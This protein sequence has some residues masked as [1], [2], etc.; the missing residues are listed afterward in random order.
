M[1]KALLAVGILVIGS[2]AVGAQTAVQDLP[3]LKNYESERA[4]SYDRTGG[5]GDYRPIGPGQTITI[6]DEDG[7][8]QV[9][10]IWATIPSWAGPNTLTSVVMRMYWDDEKT[11][12]VE[13]PIG[14]FFGLGL[15]TYTV[16]QSA[17]VAVLPKQP[18]NSYFPMPFQKHGRITVTN[19]GTKEI[20]D[21]YWNIDWLKKQSLDQ[22]TGYLHAQYSVRF[23]K[24]IRVTIE[25]GAQ[26]LRSDNFYS[27]AYWYQREPH[28]P[29]PVLPSA[30]GRI[31]RLAWVGRARPGCLHAIEER[32][33]I[34][35]EPSPS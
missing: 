10:H 25:D 35:R 28:V 18:L 3:E 16:F 15:G 21:Y 8:G 23:R 9:Q 30:A 32:K 12:S 5:N 24:S 22:N 26:N 2:L 34:G 13:S 6:F 17:L 4:S 20:S 7:P 19:E 14:A 1:V 29:F 31:P 11:P 33:T 27:V